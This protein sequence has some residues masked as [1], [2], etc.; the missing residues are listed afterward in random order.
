MTRCP[1]E[2][3]TRKVMLESGVVL[4]QH[5]LPLHL[6]L[7]LLPLTLF[8]CARFLGITNLLT[9]SLPSKPSLIFLS[10]INLYLTDSILLQ[11]AHTFF[12]LPPRLLAS[13]I[14][15]LP[16]TQEAVNWL[17]EH[18]LDIWKGDCN[19]LISRARWPCSQLSRNPFFS[20]SSNIRISSSLLLSHFWVVTIQKVTMQ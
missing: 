11:P 14:V 15:L 8:L 17:Q 10:I 19:A 7:I 1:W 4:P 9:I 13:S 20:S 2:R 18:E 6:C 12:H 3:T 16:D 5:F